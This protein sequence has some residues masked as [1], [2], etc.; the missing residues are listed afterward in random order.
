MSERQCRLVV[1][2]EFQALNNSMGKPLEE[3]RVEY[4]KCAKIAIFRT[5]S[6]MEFQALGCKIPMK[7]KYFKRPVTNKNI[8]FYYKGN[9]WTKIL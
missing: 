5:Q 6:P 7:T 4:Q 3:I 8:L 1:L 2:M 9:Q